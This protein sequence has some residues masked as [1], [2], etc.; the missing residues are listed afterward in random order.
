M[1][2]FTVAKYCVP[3]WAL[4]ALI[5]GDDS[6]LEV[7]DQAAIADFFEREDLSNGHWSYCS[8]ESYFS[9]TNDIHGL[10]ANCVDVEWIQWIE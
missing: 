10:G 4:S 5:Q 6:G 3:E 9:W 8:S 1:K 7:E 2:E